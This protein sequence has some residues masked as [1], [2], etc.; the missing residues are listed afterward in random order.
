MSSWTEN[1]SDRE[2]VLEGAVRRDLPVLDF[3]VVAV[4]AEVV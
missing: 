4:E 1:E 2:A 3:G